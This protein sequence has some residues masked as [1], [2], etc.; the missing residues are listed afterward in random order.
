MTYALASQAKF[1]RNMRFLWRMQFDPKCTVFVTDKRPTEDSFAKLVHVIYDYHPNLQLSDSSHV[2][3][4]FTMHPHTYYYEPTPIP[5]KVY[6]LTDRRYDLLFVGN[7]DPG[8]ASRAIVEDCSILDRHTIVSHLVKNPVFYSRISQITEW[9][10]H[11]EDITVPEDK[12]HVILIGVRIWQE[13]WLRTLA[14][15]NFALCPPGILYPLSY[16]LIET[17][18]VGTIPVLNYADWMFPRLQDGINCIEFKTLDELDEK[19]QAISGMDEGKIAAMRQ[20]VT[21]Y[22][23]QYLEPCRFADRLLNSDEKFLTLHTL[24]GYDGYVRNAKNALSN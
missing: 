9:H 4:P 1:H 7:S 12:T 13:N 23:D 8:Y 5:L 15:S 14:Q 3:M 2:V 22:Y 24:D 20:A 16:N 17:M 10:Q 18:A 11:F 19:I 6:R 21:N